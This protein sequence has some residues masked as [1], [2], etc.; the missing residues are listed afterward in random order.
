MPTLIHQ[1]E[2]LAQFLLRLA[3]GEND[4]ADWESLIATHYPDEFLEEMRRSVVRLYQGRLDCPPDTDFASTILRSWAIALNGETQ[5]GDGCAGDSDSAPVWLTLNELVVLDELL[6]RYS[7]TD[8]LVA[9]HPA[10]QQTLWNLQC[11]IEKM[12]TR[13]D[14]PSLDAAREG[15]LPTTE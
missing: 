5:A 15:V 1:R 8:E 3:N 12:G 6:R 10:D 4:T 9:E 2:K 13:P 11:V 7:D 14:W